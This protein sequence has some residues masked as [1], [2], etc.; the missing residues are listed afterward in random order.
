MT[1]KSQWCTA[2]KVY[3][4]L[5]PTSMMGPVPCCPYARTQTEEALSLFLR[6]TEGQETWRTTCWIFKLLFQ[7]DACYFSCFI[8]QSKSCGLMMTD[9]GLIILLQGGYIGE[10]KSNLPQ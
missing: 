10:E 7:S 2:T 1:P 4:L 9:L 5:T 8:G 3:F 6:N